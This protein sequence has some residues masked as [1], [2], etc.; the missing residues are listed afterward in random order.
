M[1]LPFILLPLFLVFGCVTTDPNQKSTHWYDFEDPFKL[2]KDTDSNWN[3]MPQEGRTTHQP[4]VSGYWPDLAG[5]IARRWQKDSIW[6][7]V[8]YQILEEASIKRLSKDKIKLLS[9]A[10]KMDLFFGRYDFPLT[11]KTKAEADSLVPGWSGLCNGVAIASVLFH[12]PQP[13]TLKGPS[14][15]EIPFGSSDFKALLAYHYGR[16][17]QVTWKRVGK[18]CDLSNPKNLPPE[19]EDLNPAVFQLLLSHYIGK[20]KTPILMDLTWDYMVWNFA[21][22]YFRTET[23]Q[24]LTKTQ[25]E[26]IL[27]GKVKIPPGLD[28]KKLR[29]LMDTPSNV[30]KVYFVHTLVSF[31]RS[32][33]DSSYK[34]ITGVY[35]KNNVPFSY[36]LFADKNDRLIGGEWISKVR[37]D[38]AWIP[39][40]VPISGDIAQIMEQA[41]AKFSF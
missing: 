25:L 28:S 8:R 13:K 35:A 15:I 19:C 40:R 2:A 31:N 16:E 34:P 32:P 36:F 3:T 27:S 20:K 23:L 38:F 39:A 29:L 30:E 4:W 26:L 12:E 14:G 9:P 1:K 6:D 7:Q 18:R 41:D 37:P 22:F 21:A 5:C 11:R 17:R 10:E 33:I 24:E